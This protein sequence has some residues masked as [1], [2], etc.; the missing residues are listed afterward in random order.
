MTI[1]RRQ[2]ATQ[3]PVELYCSWFCP[4][5]QR[6]WIAME[7]KGVEYLY[8]EMNPYEH[9]PTAPGVSRLPHHTQ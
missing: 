4:F 1:E 2:Q 5:A 3:A 7:E 8:V 6:A 9:D